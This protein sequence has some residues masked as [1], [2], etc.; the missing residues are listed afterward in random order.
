VRPVGFDLRIGRLD[1]ALAAAGALVFHA[2]DEAL[3]DFRILVLAEARLPRR[4][5]SCGGPPNDGDRRGGGGEGVG[6][7]HVTGWRQRLLNLL[8]QRP[9][10]CRGGRRFGA[11][12]RAS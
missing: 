12:G 5:Q 11:G 3:E 9:Q 4:E 6:F 8:Q 1:V 7:P 10:C 2:R